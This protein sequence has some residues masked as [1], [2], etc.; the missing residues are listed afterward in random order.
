MSTAA[1]PCGEPVRF[2]AGDSLSWTKNLSSYTPADGWSL[3]YSFRGN[4]AKLDV[5]STVLNAGH[6]VSLATTQT[7][8]LVPGTYAVSGYAVKGTDQRFNFFTGQVTV[9]ANLQA[10][11]ESFDP[12]TQE[13][14]TLDNINAV[15]EGRAS[16][17][18][19]KSTVEGTVLERI[20]HTDLMNLQALYQVKVRNQEIEALQ[21][22]GKP[23]GRTIFT[24]F[25][26][27]K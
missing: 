12:R 16:K 11:D 9:F 5:A 2:T 10:A 21:L 3:I 8:A 22:Q 4:G 25:T 1:I 23:T 15:I 19:L 7:T 24:T 13:R 27:P 14:R 18:I 17:T 26:R 6:L 20:P